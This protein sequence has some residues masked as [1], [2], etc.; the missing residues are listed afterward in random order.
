MSTEQSTGRDWRALVKSLTEQADKHAA[1][2]RR[3]FVNTIATYRKRHDVGW[4][5]EDPEHEPAGREGYFFYRP[6]QL[7]VRNSALAHVECVLAGLGVESCGRKSRDRSPVTRLVVASR[8]PT[9]ALVRELR[10]L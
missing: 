6:G 9:P 2:M 10:R 7:L 4:W 5:P 8:V 3:R 1:D